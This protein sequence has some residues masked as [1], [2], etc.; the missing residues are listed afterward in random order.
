M[1]EGWRNDTRPGYFGR[2][3]DE[4]VG[5]LIARWGQGNWR[6]VWALPSSDDVCEFEQ[7]CKEF[8]E[9]SYFRWLQARPEAV[10]FI[11]MHNEV[12]D[13][14]ITNIASGLDYKKQESYS[15]HI[16][17]IAIRNCLR[18]LGVWFRRER[19][20]PLQIRGTGEGE[21]YNPGHIPFYD[22]SLISKPSLRPQWAEEGSVEDFW[23]SNKWIQVRGR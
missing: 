12:Y 4:I 7:A 23:Q 20:V 15:T 9:E 16:Q 3:R 17:D 1:P 21:K 10:Q 19:N 14:A 5:G 11:T 22:P 8:Y 2:R 18:R 13:N 6:L